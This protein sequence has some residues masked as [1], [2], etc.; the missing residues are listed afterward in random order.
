MYQIWLKEREAWIEKVREN[1]E[2]LDENNDLKK[3]LTNEIELSIEDR[4]SE[5]SRS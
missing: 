5:A 2:L 3:K 1:N 4:G